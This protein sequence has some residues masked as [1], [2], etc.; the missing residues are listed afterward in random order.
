V[1]TTD[2]IVALSAETVRVPPMPSVA[3]R[4]ARWLLA[5]APIVGLFVWAAGVRRDLPEQLTDP[6]YVLSLAVVGALSLA[7][8]ALALAMSV[9]DD[10]R[11][12]T[13]TIL[14]VVLALAWGGSLVVRLAGGGGIR[15]GLAADAGHYACAVQIVLVALVPMVILLGR[16]RAGAPT[17]PAWTG[18]LAVMAAGGAAAAGASIVC[19]IDESAHLML[20][21]F[22]PVISLAALGA[23]AGWM[24]LDRLRS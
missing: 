5:S 3:S 1:R 8:A 6:A 7:A 2:L 10:R 15:S 23:A 11:S 21:H 19:P 13:V 22:L 24:W 20:W 18:M 9:P 12:R 16:V 14:P 4:F 17:R